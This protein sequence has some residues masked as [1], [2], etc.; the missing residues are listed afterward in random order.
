MSPLHPAA[1]VV[2]FC[3][4]LQEE[5]GT[6]AFDCQ[7]RQDMGG[8]R[9]CEGA[10]EG[11]CVQR[12]RRLHRSPG[13]STPTFA[14]GAFTDLQNSQNTALPQSVLPTGMGRC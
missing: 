3:P 9:R 1:F 12:G 11:T 5:S 14:W 7:V 6:L 8:C 4:P 13:H 2:A 10:Q